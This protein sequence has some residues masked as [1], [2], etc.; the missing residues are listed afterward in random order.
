[1][2]LHLAHPAAFEPAGLTPALAATE[3]W[4]FGIV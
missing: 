1:M 4:T 2:R 3:G